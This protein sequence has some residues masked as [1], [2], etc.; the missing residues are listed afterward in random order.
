MAYSYITICQRER[1]RENETETERQR[2]RKKERESSELLLAYYS[3]TVI[4]GNSI[5]FLQT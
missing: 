4:L 5:I 1:E 3:R 2:D